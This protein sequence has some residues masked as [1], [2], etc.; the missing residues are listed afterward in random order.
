[1]MDPNFNY[2][3]RK[4]NTEETNTYIKQCCGSTSKKCGC[5]SRKKSQCGCGSGFKLL[6]N[7]GE[8]SIS[9]NL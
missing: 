8:P 5:G 2:K 6:L 4:F 9:I 1:M 3:G 7:S